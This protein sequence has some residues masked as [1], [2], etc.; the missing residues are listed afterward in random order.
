V[1]RS[2]GGEPVDRP[3][4]RRVISEST[5]ASVREMLRGVLAAGGTASEATIE[6]Y[7]LAG[8]TGTAN[9]VDAD[10]GEYSETRYIASFVGFAPASRPELLVSVV[11]DEPQ[12][13]AIYGGEVAAP[14][15][16]KIVAF[17]LPYLG[18][19]PS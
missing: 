11:V 14:A 16:Q 10:T 12:G 5:S 17:A 19:R 1:I 18:I 6:G 13:G 3:T 8:K 15:F 2:V 9:K 4:G 7:D